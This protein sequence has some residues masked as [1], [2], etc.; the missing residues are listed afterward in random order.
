[1][2]SVEEY[3][4]EER[5]IKKL[6]DELKTRKPTI[7]EIKKVLDFKIL[8]KDSKQKWVINEYFPLEHHEKHSTSYLVLKPYN[9]GW[10]Y[11]NE[12]SRDYGMQINPEVFEVKMTEQEVVD[13]Y[14]I[15]DYGL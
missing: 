2:N 14:V 13:K 15:S 5:E 7:K 3:E 9:K 12:S 6:I 1:M 4:K 10:F 8:H 11:R